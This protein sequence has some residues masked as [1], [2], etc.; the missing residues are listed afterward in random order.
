MRSSSRFLAAIAMTAIVV[1]ACSST[2]ATP[3]VAPVTPAPV[4]PAPVTAA[5][6]TAP[7]TVASAPAG[8]SISSFDAAFTAMAQLTSVTSAGS[9][10]VGV[11]LPDVTTSARYTSYDLPYLTQAFTAAGYTASQFKIQNASGTT[12]TEVAIAQADIAA[13]AKVLLVDPLD[14][15]TGKQIQS[16]AAAAGIPMISY[17]RATFQGTSTY[18]VSFDNVQVGK[19]IGQGFLDCV[20]AWNVKSPM[21][22]TLDGGQDTDPNAISF[23]TGYNSVVWGQSVAQVADGATNNGMTLVHEQLAP[24]WDN[25]QGQTIFKTYYTGHKQINATIEANDGL[26]NAVI[27]DLKA[28][29][30]AAK[31]VP[32]VG[33]DATLAGMENVL[34]G[35]QCGSVYKP[36]YLEAQAAVALAT[37]LRAGQTPPATLVN[38][39][40]K[41][42]ASTTTEPAVLLVPYWVN[43]ANMESTVI[44]DKFVSVTDLC[45]AVGAAVC[46]TAGIQ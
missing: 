23:A 37:Y 3:T 17:D 42:P 2:T 30:I 34:N 11:I 5:P 27:T 43:A 9:G 1:G 33:Q 24:G 7:T 14:G 8:L 31:T 21:V 4:T 41:D 15:P 19:L 22:F 20:T 36:V 18:Y 6:T 45:N 16:L 29:G 40:T 28:A 13:G 39:T 26:A 46:T 32:T 35:W 25:A 10:M 38:G 44:K 12:T